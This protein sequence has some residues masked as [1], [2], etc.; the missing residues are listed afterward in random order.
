MKDNMV[1]NRTI[2]EKIITEALQ[3]SGLLKKVKGY[4]FRRW[5]K[6]KMKLVEKAIR[7]ALYIKDNQ[8][9]IC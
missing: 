4:Y 1:S 9:K 8:S 3:K 6:K 5:S 2:N 7:R